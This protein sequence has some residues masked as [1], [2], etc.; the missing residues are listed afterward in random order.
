MRG[1]RVAQ[2]AFDRRS[3]LAD[4]QTLHHGPVRG[5]RHPF[6]LAS[7]DTPDDS[8]RIDDLEP[9]QFLES[10]CRWKSA[11]GRL[12]DTSRN[13]QQV[14]SPCV[15]HR[16]AWKKGSGDRVADSAEAELVDGVV[17]LE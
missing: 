5:T 7:S 17:V 10:P 12:V 11:P 13:E 15:Q 9:L 4:L 8:E 2:Q 16:D 14:P 6:D 3:R 1:R